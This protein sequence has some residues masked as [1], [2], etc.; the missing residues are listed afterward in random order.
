MGVGTFADVA[1][2]HQAAGPTREVSAP[3][4]DLASTVPTLVETGCAVQPFAATAIYGMLA[5][6]RERRMPSNRTTLL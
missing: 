2:R 4:C 5:H 1:Q 3:R 6:R